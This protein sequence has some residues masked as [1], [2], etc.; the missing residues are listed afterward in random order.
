[1]A[2]PIGYFTSGPGIDALIRRYGDQL[3]GLPPIEKRELLAV[4]TRTIA[5][6][7][8]LRPET[9][10]LDDEMSSGNYEEISEELYDILMLM[11]DA[12]EIKLIELCS[13]IVAQLHDEAVQL[14]QY[15]QSLVESRVPRGLAVQAA[16]VMVMQ[17]AL[18]SE[19]DLDTIAA[20][21]R[22][23]TETNP[24]LAVALYQ[25]FLSVAIAR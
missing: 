9:W 25:R 16:A 6:A 22:I 8:A 5:V 11:N 20:T 13:A 18:A 23:L 17:P 3:Q 12:P 14:Y 19:E 2:R 15:A 4:L 21:Y 7:A 24:D 1:M 10:T